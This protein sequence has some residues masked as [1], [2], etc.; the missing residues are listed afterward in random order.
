MAELPGWP[1]QP[2]LEVFRVVGT[3]AMTPYQLPYC[4][5]PHGMALVVK[6]Y[7]TNGGLVYISGTSHGVLNINSAYPLVASEVLELFGINAANYYMCAAVAGESI[8]CVVE[9]ATRGG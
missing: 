5:I 4:M 6:G 1:N 7:P 2:F 8:I 3:A 9:K